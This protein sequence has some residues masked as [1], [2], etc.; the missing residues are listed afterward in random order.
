M[1]LPRGARK[2]VALCSFVDKGAGELRLLSQL[3]RVKN[4]RFGMEIQVTGLDTPPADHRG[5][6]RRVEEARRLI[7]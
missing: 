4:G 2:T 5:V 3:G 1:Q 6:E 7:D